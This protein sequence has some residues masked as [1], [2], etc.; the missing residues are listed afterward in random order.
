M[1]TTL[2]SDRLLLEPITA[3][4][5]HFIFELVNTERWLKY[6]GNRNVTTPEEANTYIE[7]KLN[8]SSVSSWIVK[9]KCNLD[10]IGIITFIKRD[11][12]LHYDIGFAFLPRA[13]NNGY[14]YEAAKAVLLMLTND[15]GHSHILATTLPENINSIKLLIKLG[16][17]YDREIEV[18]GEKLHIYSS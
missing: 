13:A 10:S 4:D 8:S 15:P 1:Q 17:H 2:S 6:I 7:E 14:A 18:D 16:F 5:S 3:K 9:L 11:Y 12:L